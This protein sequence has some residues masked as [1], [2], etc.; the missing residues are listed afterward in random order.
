MSMTP[1]FGWWDY[2]ANDGPTLIN[3][4]SGERVRFSGLMPAE[5]IV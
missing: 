2:D 4:E 5:A 1:G 3:R